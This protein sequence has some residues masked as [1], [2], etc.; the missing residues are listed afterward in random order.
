MKQHYKYLIIGAGPAGLQMAYFLKKNNLDYIVL[1]KSSSTENFFSKYP[2]HRRLISINKKNNFFEEEEFNLRHDWNTLLSEE[3]DKLKFTNYSDELFP[4][5]DL[6]SKYFSDYAAHNKLN[7]KY[8]HKVSK[9]SK[10]D[11][12]VF[13][14]TLEDKSILTANIL[15]VAT[16]AVRQNM[17]EEIEGIEHTTKYADFQLD[18]KKY[19]NKRVAIIGSGNSAFETADSISDVAAFAHIFTR[20]KVKLAYETHFVG[21]VRAKYTNIFDMYQLKSLYAILKPRI[22]KITKLEN[23]CLQTQHEYDYPE[24]T[25]PGTLKLT[26][27][28]DYIINCSGFKYTHTNLFDESIIPETVMN[29][30]FY[31]LT[32]NWESTNVPNLYFIGTLMQAIDRKSSSGFI[33]GFRY[34]I[35]SLFNILNEKLENTTYPNEKIKINPFDKF[36]EKMYNRSSVGDGIFQLFSFLG[37]KLVYDEQT[38]EITWYKEQP[39]AYINK[40]INPNEHTLVLTLDFGFQHY[41]QHSSLDFMGPSDPND[42]EKAVFLHPVIR[43]YYNYNMEEFHFGDSL[44]GRWDMP[45][46]SGGAIASYHTEFYNW[47]ANIFD[48]EI[49]DISTIGENPNYEV[50]HN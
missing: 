27:E 33:H 2:I 35:R 18:K 47:M 42:T 22:K 4:N 21:H 30:K 49:K 26:R 12:D 1:E 28:Y 5:A 32:E 44:L 3:S 24:S 40:N 43:H 6:L 41:P 36:L 25:N 23:G 31:N 17:P 13:Q 20:N 19:I 10:L 50:W 7:I 29:D 16:G 48:I 15:F 8:N 37:D 38:K 34:N 9:I 45:H 39:V 14:I 11:E 46:A